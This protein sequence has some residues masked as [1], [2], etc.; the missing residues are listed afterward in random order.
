VRLTEKGFD[1]SGGALID[2]HTMRCDAC[3]TT[4]VY[5][6]VVGYLRPYVSTNP[7]K[8][9]EIRDRKMFDLTAI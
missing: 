2:E 3:M 7:G 4:E 6:R 8:Q 1:I 5:S 9:A